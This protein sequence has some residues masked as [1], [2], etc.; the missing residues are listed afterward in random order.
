M[1]CKVCGYTNHKAE[2]SKFRGHLKK[3]CIVQHTNYCDNSEISLFAI[4]S[5]KD[6]PIKVKVYIDHQPFFM[7]LDTGSENNV[8]SEKMYKGC[9]IRRLY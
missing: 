1:Q 9:L 7:E 3:I 8:I 5:C 4:N 2:N 6:E